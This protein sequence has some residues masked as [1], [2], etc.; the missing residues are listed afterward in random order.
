MA[1]KSALVLV[2]D[3]SE[4]IETLA[5]V[6]I[7]RRAKTQVTL[8]AVCQ[9]GKTVTCSRG[10]RVEADARIEEVQDKEFD[11]IVCPGGM[12][13]ATN[14]AASETLQGKLKAQAARG[15][16]I[17]A[18][19]AAPAVVLAPLGLLDNKPAT[20]HPGFAEKLQGVAKDGCSETRVVVTDDEKVITSR[21]PGTAIEFALQIVELLH[22]KEVRDQVAAPMVVAPGL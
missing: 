6:D 18:I 20:C 4:E 1:E 21:G 12:P 22:G 9:E 11:I 3:G 2:A 14:L 13:G 5:P 19:C 10:V 7:L 15:A 17:G 16:I 8:A